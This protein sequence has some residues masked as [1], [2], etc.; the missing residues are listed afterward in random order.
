VNKGD[1]TMFD[2]NFRLFSGFAGINSFC[3]KT[4]LFTMFI[5]EAVKYTARIG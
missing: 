2:A 5:L 1:R 4:D 3:I